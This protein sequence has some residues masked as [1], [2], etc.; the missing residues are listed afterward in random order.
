MSFW[1]PGTYYGLDSVVEYEGAKYKVIQAHTS[2][3][4]WEPPLTPALTGTVEMTEV[5]TTAAETTR[6]AR[7]RGGEEHKWY[8][9]DEEKKKE[10]EIGGGLLA[11]AAA[12]GAGFYAYKKHKE[13]EEK[14]RQEDEY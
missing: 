10:L 6:S 14:E 13:N 2:E 1:E 3:S 11:G 12:I 8:D 7:T 9:L 4:G 5:T